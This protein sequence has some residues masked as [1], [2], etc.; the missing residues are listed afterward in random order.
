[1][2]ELGKPIREWQIE[3]PKIPNNIPVPKPKEAEPKKIEEPVK[4]GL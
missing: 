4:V 2:A 3:E 1:M